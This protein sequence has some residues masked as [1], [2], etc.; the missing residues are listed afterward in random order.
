MALGCWQMYCIFLCPNAR[1]TRKREIFWLFCVLFFTFPPVTMYSQQQ[2]ERDRGERKKVSEKEREAGKEQKERKDRI[3]LD[4]TWKHNLMV[5]KSICFVTGVCG[6]LLPR[7][8]KLHWNPR[9]EGS[10]MSV[11]E[12][13]ETCHR[14][15]YTFVLML[16]VV[17][18]CVIPPKSRW[19]FSDSN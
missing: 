17:A 16:M 8:W 12:N 1:C 15:L 3:G 10:K 14:I 13:M 6:D 18:G 4:E 19:T 5:K 2:R 7:K 9:N 11:A